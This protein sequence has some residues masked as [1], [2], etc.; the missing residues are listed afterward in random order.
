MSTGKQPDSPQQQREAISA[1]AKRHGL[2]VDL[3]YRDDGISGLESAKRPEFTR[4]LKDAADGKIG[5]ILLWDIDR[6]SR[7]DSMEAAS[8]IQPL[9]D[10]RVQLIAEKQGV[11]DLES[12]AGRVMFTLNQEGKNEFIRSLSANVARGQNSRLERGK[13]MILRPKYGWEKVFFDE[14]GVEQR[15]LKRGENW[16][17][18]DQWTTSLV[19]SRDQT[20]VDTVRYIF[21]SYAAG[22]SP[23]A[24]RNKLNGDRVPGPSGNMWGR[25]SIWDILTHPIF[26]GDFAWGRK[27]KSKFNEVSSGGVRSR[28]VGETRHKRKPPQDWII[29]KDQF[30]PMVSRKLW[31]RVQSLL[32]QNAKMRSPK[33]STYHLTKLVYCGHCGAPMYGSSSRQSIGADCRYVCSSYQIRGLKACK[34]YSIQQTP[35]VKFLIGKIQEIVGIGEN[36]KE[37]RKRIAEALEKR[38]K[39]TTK[40]GAD[41]TRRLI[42]LESKIDRMKRRVADADDDL[43]AILQEQLRDLLATKKNL[44]ATLKESDSPLPD[45]GELSVDEVMDALDTIDGNLQ[46]ADP[47][48]LFQVFHD[49]IERIDLHFGHTHRGKRDFYPLERG[50]LTL[51]ATTFLDGSVVPSPLGIESGTRHSR[52]PG[53][54]PEWT[55]RQGSNRS[56]ANGFP[57]GEALQRSRGRD[58]DTALLCRGRRCPG[59]GRVSQQPRLVQPGMAVLLSTVCRGMAPVNSAGHRLEIAM[60]AEA[61]PEPAGGVIHDSGCGQRNT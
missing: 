54:S 33:R 24:I 38:K 21:E 3:W 23:G 43:F 8:F 41:Q 27:C 50:V 39:T 40:A 57:G 44:E 34:S 25:E 5:T 42:D 58:R 45:S 51:R 6:L 61:G 59:P 26:C 1:L 30:P 19:W 46:S 10:K 15:R 17:C 12:F 9:R 53:L 36:R 60:A 52:L 2:T 29:I 37:V 49:L 32:K 22:M 47:A 28:V 11:I 14:K 20:E 4:L 31:E 35:L 18:P 7:F 16:H 48:R 13:M 56:H 55:L